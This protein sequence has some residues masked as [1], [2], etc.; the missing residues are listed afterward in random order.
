MYNTG[1]TYLRHIWLLVVLTTLFSCGLSIVLVA[2][3]EEKKEKK[4]MKN[5]KRLSYPALRVFA[6]TC[7]N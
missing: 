3:G 1:P 2:G 5:R 6:N 7:I 4:R